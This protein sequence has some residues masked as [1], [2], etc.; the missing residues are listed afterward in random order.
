MHLPIEALGLPMVIIL[1]RYGKAK[2]GNYFYLGSLLGT[3]ITDV[4]FYCVGLIPYWKALMMR[5]PAEA[6]GILHSALLRM[7]TYQ[8]VGCAIVLLT[9]LL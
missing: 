7:E 8:G 5:P 2:I 9:L 1:M 3:A 4:Y 6:G